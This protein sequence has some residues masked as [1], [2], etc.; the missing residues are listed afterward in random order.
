MPAHTRNRILEGA[1]ALGRTL[2]PVV[3]G[4]EATTRARA[5]GFVSP[6][7]NEIIGRTNLVVSQ[8]QKSM[9]E[10]AIDMVKAIQT[11]SDEI[12]DL[13]GT[14]PKGERTSVLNQLQEVLD[15]PVFAY[16][17]AWIKTLEFIVTSNKRSIAAA[18][19]ERERR[20]K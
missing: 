12:T 10:Q 18:R 11:L 20:S 16:T 8:I 15:L 7:V 14:L 4:K 5:R 1:L 19:K 9:A 2:A 6:A 13:A 17:E 3:F